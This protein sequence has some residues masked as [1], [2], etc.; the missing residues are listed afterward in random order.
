MSFSDAKDAASTA[1]NFRQRHGEQINSGWKAAS[2]LNQKYGVSDKVKGWQTGEASSPVQEPTPTARP[3]AHVPEPSPVSPVS[4]PTGGQGKRPPPP[5]PKKRQLQPNAAEQPAQGD[6][7][8]PIP[9]SS[10]PR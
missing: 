4:V 7:P 5:P 2:G 10:K 1:N 3:A 6:A 9:L 8:P